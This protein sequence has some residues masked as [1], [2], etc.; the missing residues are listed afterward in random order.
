MGLFDDLFRN[1]NSQKPNSA[2]PLNIIDNPQLNRMSQLPDLVDKFAKDLMLY[3]GRMAD[4]QEYVSAS[5]TIS[6]VAYYSID[7]LIEYKK[8]SLDS[9]PFSVVE[10]VKTQVLKAAQKNFETFN[11]DYIIEKL[12]SEIDTKIW[13]VDIILETQN[14]MRRILA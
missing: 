13:E 6:L 7:L 9:L 12:F 11:R 3:F 5:Q 14:Y 8:N 10:Q 4:K 1:E 2:N